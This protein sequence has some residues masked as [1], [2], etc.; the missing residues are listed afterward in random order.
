MVRDGNVVAVTMK[1]ADWVRLRDE[2][3]QPKTYPFVELRSAITEVVTD[4]RRV[5]YPKDG[6]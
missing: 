3:S 4:A 6:E 5:Y 1:I 2:I